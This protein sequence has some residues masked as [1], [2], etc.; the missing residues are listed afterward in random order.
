MHLAIAAQKQKIGAVISIRRGN[1]REII[2]Q[3]S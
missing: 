1:N 3:D 2:F